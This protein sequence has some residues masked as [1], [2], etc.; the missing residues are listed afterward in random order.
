VNPVDWLLDSDSDPA[1][2]WQALRDLTDVA[3]PAIAAELAR[4]PREGLGAAIL[5]HQQPDGSWRREGAPAWLTTL[6]TLQLLR[7]TGADP[8]DPAIEKGISR[9]EST[10]YFDCTP[11][12]WD[13]RPAPDTGNPFFQGEEEPCINGGVL[14]LGGYFAHPNEKLARRL[15]C[16]QLPDGGWNCDAPKS[17]RSSFHTTICVLEGLLEYERAISASAKAQPQQ[18]QDPRQPDALANEIAAAR[19]RAEEYLLARSLLRRRSTG[20]VAS[21]EFLELSFPPRYHYDILRAL[22]YFRSASI[23]AVANAHV[24]SKPDPRLAEAIQLIERK[25]QPDGRW[26]LENSYTESLALPLAESIGQPSR[27]NT[28]RALRVLRWYRQ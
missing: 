22:D 16:E 4:V 13:L 9:L 5:A 7:A 14:A 25:R 27:W 3:L 20:A 21:P 8:N 24:K 11:G 23:H 19:H 10:L 28:L 17:Q 6:F 15:L 26:L 12:C 1:I 18:K 2:R